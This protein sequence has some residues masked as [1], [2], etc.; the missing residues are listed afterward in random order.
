MDTGSIPV[1][2]AMCFDRYYDLTWK[3]L[4]DGERFGF[5]GETAG[6]LIPTTMDIFYGVSLGRYKNTKEYLEDRYPDM[7]DYFI[8]KRGFIEGVK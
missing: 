1:R 2:G 4:D 5:G 7:V 6:E 8:F 3:I